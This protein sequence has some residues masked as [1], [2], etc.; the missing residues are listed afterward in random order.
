MNG[1]DPFS[2]G[3]VFDEEGRKRF[4]VAVYEKYGLRLNADDPLFLIF[5]LFE[6][7]QR[8]N[9]ERWMVEL[10]A[11]VDM[12]LA[13]STETLARMMDRLEGNLVPLLREVFS[14]IEA[15]GIQVKHA[16]AKDLLS[17]AFATQCAATIAA[18]VREQLEVS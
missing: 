16:I 7:L 13:R 14:G 1:R 5:G 10:E 11:R 3:V 9:A 8:K 15:K 6:E 12:R 17:E 2:E 18:K 4:A